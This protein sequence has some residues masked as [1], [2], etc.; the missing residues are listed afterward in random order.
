MIL[1]LPCWGIVYLAKWHFSSYMCASSCSASTVKAN[2]TSNAVR[3][4]YLCGGDR[5]CGPMAF[6]ICRDGGAFAMRSS[7]RGE[8]AI[9]SISFLLG[10]SAVSNM[11]EEWAKSYHKY[12]WVNLQASLS[13]TPPLKYFCREFLWHISGSDLLSS[14]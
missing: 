4:G 13:L 14:R 2:V 11:L 10:Q 9:N 3:I 12:V 8:S 5:L 1:I 7:S 6:L